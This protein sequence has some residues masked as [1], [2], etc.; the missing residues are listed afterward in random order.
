MAYNVPTV[1]DVFLPD[2][3]KCAAF[4][5]AQENVA[6]QNTTKGVRTF[7]TKVRVRARLVFFIA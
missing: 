2:K 1:T 4:L 7:R 5:Q 6:E 3:E